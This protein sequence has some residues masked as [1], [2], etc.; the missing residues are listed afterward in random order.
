[1]GWREHG[2]EGVIGVSQAVVAAVERRFGIRA[3]VISPCVDTALFKPRR[4][5]PSIAYMPRRNEIGI[6]E[7]LALAKPSEFRRVPIRGVPHNEVVTPLSQ[8]SIFVAAS[9]SEGF[10]LPSL[11]AMASGCLVVGFAGGGGLDFMKDGF[12]CLLAEDGNNE[13]AA[14]KLKLA[15]RLVSENKHHDLVE[16]AVRTA[17]EF[18]PEREERDLVNFWT[19]FLARKGTGSPTT[20]SPV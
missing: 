3:T 12:N 4:K 5:D 10:G 1:M 19:E 18:S 13:E 11:E 17:R 20:G 6:D 8:A 2:V 16:N 14:E 15:M 7:I 9:Y